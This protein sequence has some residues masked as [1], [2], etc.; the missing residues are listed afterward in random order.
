[1]NKIKF[2]DLNGWLKAWIIG[3]PIA[4]YVWASISFHFI[5]DA[6]ELML[7]IDES[8]IE[9]IKSLMQFH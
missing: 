4:L 5:N 1:M 3:A 8:L 7:E 2:K 9:L 6:L